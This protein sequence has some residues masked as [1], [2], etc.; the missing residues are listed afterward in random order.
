LSINRSALHAFFKKGGVGHHF[1]V[2]DEKTA[3]KVA[4]I[5]TDNDGKTLL[6]IG[7]IELPPDKNF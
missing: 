7:T 5:L 2:P 6:S 1:F 3:E 4:A